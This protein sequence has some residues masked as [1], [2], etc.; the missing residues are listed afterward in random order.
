[1]LRSLKL[2]QQFM[3]T[4]VTAIFICLAIGAYTSS[5]FMQKYLL[6][7]ELQLSQEIADSFGEKIDNKKNN[8]LMM[9]QF[10]AD[11][12]NVQQAFYKKDKATLIALFA[13]QFPEMKKNYGIRQFQFHLPPA[14]SF[15][16]IHKIEK[17]GDDLSGFR[18]TV[19]ETNKNEK[20]VAGLEV[21]VA[22]IGIRGVVPMFYK[23]EHQGSVEFGLSLDQY[24]FDQFTEQH[25]IGAILHLSK[26][27]QLSQFV[28]SQMK[29]SMFSNQELSDALNGEAH[30]VQKEINGKALFAITA[31]V[32]NYAG[33]TIGLIEISRDASEFIAHNKTLYKVQFIISLLS[34]LALIVIILIVSKSIV[35][36]LNKTIKSLH[37][38]TAG[39]GDLS[40]KLDETGDDEIAIL[41]Y[42][43]NKLTEKIDFTVSD[44]NASTNELAL[45]IIRQSTL[46]NSTR[47]GVELQQK[48]NELVATAL[49]EMSATV[50]EITQNTAQA[51]ETSDNTNEEAIKGKEA[52]T[53]A[54]ESITILAEDINQA[55]ASIKRVE[56]DSMRIGSVLDVIESI[57]EQ[58]N[59]LALNAAIEA[60]RAGEAGRGFAVVAD[61]VRTLASKT[62]SSTEEI[63]EMIRSLQSAVS[64]ATNTMNDSHQQVQK[65]VELV[66]D[67]G[68]RLTQISHSITTIDDM[69]NQIATASEE[70]AVVTEDINKNVI[71][72]NNE[73]QHT[74]ENAQQS[75]MES[76]KIGSDV[77]HILKLISQFKTRD[78]NL[79]QLLRAKSS[80]SLW[81]IKIRSYLNG[82]LKLDDKT[83]SDHHHCSFGKWLD[84]TNLPDLFCKDE[85][86]EIL[87]I[88]KQLHQS[89]HS[90]ISCKE[91]NDILQAEKEYKLL[92]NYSDNVVALIDNLISQ[93]KNHK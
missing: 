92:I 43:I 72:I 74:N 54:V 18:F 28:Q 57:A 73:S 50:H 90:I 51:A 38:I 15:L 75:M 16:R 40:I 13:D 67:S 44:I 64:N 31:P 63:N 26:G 84:Q 14:T 5:Q 6:D 3:L 22:G 9:A 37:N 30:F 56:D 62:Q 48:K 24:F 68:E 17:S 2:T 25:Q 88:H 87:K 4:T 53:S 89:V 77:E 39:D 66:A 8:A 46:A 19:V 81:K 21:G 29:K 91:K 33:K 55:V 65:T 35:K 12:P 69:N 23:N 47:E 70:Q 49:N 34:L 79:A 36:P 42:E 32:S 11:M 58:T 83:S 80:H 61:E 52:S 93:T 76:I 7:V 60:A 27:E 45:N 59:L 1:M 85:I 82:Y 10:V 71:E 86:A 20:A 78:D 41:S